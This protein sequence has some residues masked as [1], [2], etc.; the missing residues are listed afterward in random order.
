MLTVTKTKEPPSLLMRV[1][2]WLDEQEDRNDLADALIDEFIALTP[3]PG[4]PPAVVRQCEVDARARG[5]SHDLAL[6]VLAT[7]L[8]L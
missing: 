3:T 4:V 1:E 5:F 7:R 8:K 6:R 2:R